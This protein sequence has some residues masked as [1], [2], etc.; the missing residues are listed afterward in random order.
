MAAN[1]NE[2]L[3][4]KL[5]TLLSGLDTV[6][7]D[8]TTFTDKGGIYI[9]I[10]DDTV[11]YSEAANVFS[12]FVESEFTVLFS[13]N[14]ASDADYNAVMGEWIDK[15]KNALYSL[16]PESTTNGLFKIDLQTIRIENIF[17]AK[18]LEDVRF[19]IIGKLIYNLYRS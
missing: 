18:D 17:K 1:T 10:G 16:T 2:Y 19:M 6:Y 5:N 13:K 9:E 8:W 3:L 11:E 14:I 15:V 7:E 4:G 12:E